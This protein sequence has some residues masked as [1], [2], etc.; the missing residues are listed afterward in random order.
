MP[1]QNRIS[2]KEVIIQLRRKASITRGPLKS[3]GN[4]AARQIF[5][6]GFAVICRLF[7]LAQARIGV[8]HRDREEEFVLH[9]GPLPSPANET[10]PKLISTFKRFTNR[11]CGEQL[12]Q[13]S[14]HEHV[15]RNETEYQQIW[16]YIDNNPA[17]W[18]ED[19]YHVE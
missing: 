14:Y 3:N 5:G 18:A 10:L 7:S 12:W 1:K 4:H 13:R 6:F 17:R 16:E 9:A 2:P 11:K 8:Y 19:R 15:I